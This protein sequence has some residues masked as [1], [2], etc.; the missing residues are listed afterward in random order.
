M[1]GTVP[2][3]LAGADAMQ[4][5][6]VRSSRSPIDGGSEYP[7]F[8]IAPFCLGTRDSRA[9]GVDEGDSKAGAQPHCLGCD[10]R[11]RFVDTARLRSVC[12]LRAEMPR[13]REDLARST[14]VES[15]GGFRIWLRCSDG[16]SGEIDFS[17][18]SGHGV[19]AAWTN[20]RFFES[21][22]IGPCGAISWGED[23]DLC[24]DAMYLRLTGKSVSDVFGR[25]D[26][27]AENA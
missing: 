26:A 27:S 3:S 15:R 16:T 13:V 8:G 24:P 2:A 9:I 19:L 7:G 4:A 1:P 11:W 14:Q 22:R 10:R 23:L 21:V 20:R 6:R 17:D 12:E 5:P 18:L 25:G